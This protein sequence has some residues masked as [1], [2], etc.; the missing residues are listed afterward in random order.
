MGNPTRRHSYTRFALRLS[1]SALILTAIAYAL[2]ERLD[3]ARLVATLHAA[4]RGLVALAA[5]LSVLSLL[6]QAIRWRQL[7]CSSG[8]DRL[9]FRQFL[10][11]LLA[12][13]PLNLL[14][15]G[16]AGELIRF[17]SVRRHLPVAVAAASVILERL[18]DLA[19]LSGFAAL[20]IFDGGRPELPAAS[21]ALFCVVFVTAACLIGGRLTKPLAWLLRRTGKEGPARPA[22][23]AADA[24]FAGLRGRPT[25]LLHTCW[26]TLLLW[27]LAIVQSWLL[28]HATGIAIP[29]R[30]ASTIVP[31]GIMATLL[32]L[33][34]G[35]LGTREAAFLLL[36]SRRA[37]PHAILAFTSLFFLAR[38]ILPALVGI[39]CLWYTTHSLLA[40]RETTTVRSEDR[41]PSEQH[42]VD[43]TAQ[44]QTRARE[45]IRPALSPP[46]EQRP[47]RP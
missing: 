15:P 43:D 4:D 10:L 30:T 5:F 34:L 28:L 31:M 13:Q 19:G 36:L 29:L 46:S 17:I 42:E 41:I 32:P 14:L 44:E 3:S 33:T 2:S 35:G 25:R 38:Y 26:L 9:A 21:L 8:G 20:G 12:A 24:F 18:L 47:H 23:R 22:L 37:D 45:E 11:P 39:P 1:G 16:R 27:A 7:L 6:L 40:G